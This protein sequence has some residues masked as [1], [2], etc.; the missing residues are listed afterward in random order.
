MR[1]P[2]TTN[3]AHRFLP[4]LLAIC[5]FVTPA[6]PARS[7]ASPAWPVVA[8]GI[9][10][11]HQRIGDAPFSIHVV[12]VRRSN[13]HLQMTSSLAQDHIYGLA[14]VSEQLQAI[15]GQVVAAVNGDFFHIRSGPYQ[16][17]PLGLQIVNGQLVSSPRGASFWIDGQGQPH[18]GP[19]ETRFRAKG[20]GD[21]P[22]AF[23]LNQERADDA[24]VLYTP[25][26]GEST[27]TPAGRELVLN[28]PSE[29][30][31]LPLRAG[32]SYVATV[33]Q[34]TDS[35]DTPLTPQTMVFSIGPKLAQELP[36]PKPGDI[37]TLSLETTPGL[38]DVPTAL[39]GGPVLIESGQLRV[40]DP[41]LP[42]HPRTAIGWDRESLFLVVVDGRQAGLSVG[43]TFPEL[44][45]LMKRLGCTEAMN[46]DGGGS[47]TLWLGGH[48][49]NS[50]S[51]GR[52]RPVA[53]C[54]AIVS[55]Q[56]RSP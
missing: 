54:L 15:E 52:E 20:L 3:R 1:T 43:M 19:V 13:A 27:R 50:P 9:E 16:G 38:K 29:E 25:S 10:Y 14:T 35:G 45:A 32:Q 34:V 23:G 4:G 22:I 41:P 26:V 12:K 51:D 44:A 48:V 55:T 21:K 53:N 33:T 46:L 17:D 2:Q 36:C 11:L 24:A 56:E 47:S 30:D 40:W 42:R 6:V 7:A 31:W 37:V 49:M 8:P 18:I 5:L 28:G 39:G